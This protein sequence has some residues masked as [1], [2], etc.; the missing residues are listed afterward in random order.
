VKYG[1]PQ[2]FTLG[3]MPLNVFIKDVSD[4]IFNSKY[5]LFADGLKIYQSTSINNVN[6][7]KLLNFG[8]DSVQ[9]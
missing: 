5:L 3:H 7:C 6:Y 2:G 1:V 9:K 8:A 4:S